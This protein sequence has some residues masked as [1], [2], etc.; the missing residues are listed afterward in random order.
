MKKCIILIALLLCFCLSIQA[1]N[2]DPEIPSTGDAVKDFVPKG[3][4]KYALAGG[5]LNKDGLDDMVVI[6]QNTSP[7][8]FKIN[9]ELGQDTLD[10][11][12]RILIIL[13]GTIN[14]SYKKALV[15]KNFI[16]KPNDEEST[17]LED[18]MEEGGI[19]INKNV[20]KI[21]FHYWQSCGSWYVTNKTYSF[22]FQNNRFELIGYDADDFH[23][24]SGEMTATS[25]NFS[26]HKKCISTGGNMFN[27]DENNSKTTCTDFPVTKLKT[28]EEMDAESEIEF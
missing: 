22:R 6:I 4:K 12:P 3:W 1:Q 26:T 21:K 18:P 13:F 25:I 28:L 19:E 11:N 27:E 8:N 5:D 2:N 10:L 17:C 14:G 9:K 15:N 24:S 23:R 7:L 16:P 20:L